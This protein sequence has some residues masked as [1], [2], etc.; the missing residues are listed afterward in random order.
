MIRFENDYAEGAHPQILQRLVATNEEQSPGYGMDEH[1]E[2]ARAYIKKAIAA[3]Q[4]DIHF[5][6]GGT[7]T[8]TTVIASI[9]RP[10]QGVIAASTGH[11]AV[12]E[13]GAIEAT[14][15]KVLTLPSDDG[16]LTAAQVKASYDAHWL[17]STHEH[18]VQPGLVYIS[19]P[20]ENG[21]TYSKAELTA[22]R[23]VCRDCDLP[24]FI[25]GAR[26]GYGLV[27]QD[28]DLSLADMAQLCDV[29]YI[30]GTKM[31][32]LF[33]EAVIIVNPAYQKDFR[34][35]IKQRGGLLA[36]G[37]LLGI[38]FETLFEDTLYMD[39]SHHAV[40]MAMM[41]RQAF[42]DKGF[43]MRYDSK[44]N[45]QFPILPNHLL[46]TL[47]EKYSFSIWEAYDDTHTVVRF[48]TSWA[49]TKENVDRLID[50]I[51]RLI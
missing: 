46:P 27:A 6:V 3:E 50:D 35:M 17:D 10:H 45:Q 47:E 13:T 5:L 30:G 51:Y 22:L 9:L 20:T 48:C 31:G 39:I 4:A 23:E 21:T 19:H 28:S 36:K 41:I 37:R 7:Q 18:M 1:S 11:I 16:K 49:T 43:A 25:D 38:Q 33:G 24:L 34:Y 12:H 29:F 44:T 15:H 14:G 2:K 26:L 8:N 32:A 40:D 42:L